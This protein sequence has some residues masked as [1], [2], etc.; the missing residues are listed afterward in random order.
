MRSP[1][2]VEIEWD[3]DGVAQTPI[4]MTLQS[5]ITYSGTIPA[6][7]DG[8]QIRFR[9]EATDNASQV[10]LSPAQGYYSGTTDIVDIR[11]NDTDGV[12][13]PF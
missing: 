9:V 11:D 4:S 13:S 10:E 5:G 1:S 6:Q 12:Y 3:L 7:T 8:K 2:T